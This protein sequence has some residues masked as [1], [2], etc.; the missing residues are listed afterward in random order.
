MHIYIYV[1]MYKHNLY[2]DYI[3][4]QYIIHMLYTDKR[5]SNTNVVI[6]K[7]H[8]QIILEQSYIC[9]SAFITHTYT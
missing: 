2:E 3:L 5:R 6:T 9:I 4:T 7:T 1:Y 8:Y